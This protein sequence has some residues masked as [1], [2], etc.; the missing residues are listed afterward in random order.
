MDDRLMRQCLQ[1]KRIATQL[2]QIRKEK[3]NIRNNR[4]IILVS[5]LVLKFNPYM[6]MY[7]IILTCTCTCMYM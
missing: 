3:D 6:H 4:Y 2:M 1:E 5:L 7:I